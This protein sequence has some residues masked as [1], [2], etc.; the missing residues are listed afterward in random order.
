MNTTLFFRDHQL[1]LANNYIF[2]L[3]L[4]NE[5]IFF[6]YA[7][8]NAT[9]IINTYNCRCS[10]HQLTKIQQ[11]RKIISWKK[12]KT[13]ESNKTFI[14]RAKVVLF[15]CH[16]IYCF[17]NF[18]VILS[19][20]QYCVCSFLPVDWMRWSDLKIQYMKMQDHAIL[21]GLREAI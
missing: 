16:L 12:N 1:L 15:R 7:P 8:K 6:S 17:L 20:A 18:P 9:L 21:Q 4:P 2:S 13:S 10:S 14:K 5:T 19:C 11:D 3:S